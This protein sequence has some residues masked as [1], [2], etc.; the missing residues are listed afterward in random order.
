MSSR[1]NRIR[2]LVDF[3]QENSKCSVKRISLNRIINMLD[4]EV[5]LKENPIQNAFKYVNSFNCEYIIIE[6]DRK[7]SAKTEIFEDLHRT[8]VEVGKSSVVILISEFAYAFSLIFKD[9]LVVDVACQNEETLKIKYSSLSTL[10]LYDRNQRE[11]VK[12]GELWSNEDFY[13][14]MIRRKING[15]LYFQKGKFSDALN[16]YND[17]LFFHSSYASDEEWSINDFVDLA[18]FV[19]CF[20]CIYFGGLEKTI[21]YEVLEDQISEI[22]HDLKQS[23]MMFYHCKMIN[24]YEKVCIG[25]LEED[26]NQTTMLSI[27]KNYVI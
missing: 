7:S 15:D 21:F 9:L 5:S 25:L 12:T 2:D 26:I 13:D 27:F 18:L 16:E 10:D 20:A 14:N 6:D 11:A 1:I 23:Y 17:A 8:L 4:K 24:D 3:F 19:R 22:I